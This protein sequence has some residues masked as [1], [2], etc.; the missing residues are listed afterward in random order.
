MSKICLHV[1]CEERRRLSKSTLGR[2]SGIIYPSRGCSWIL[3]FEREWGKERCKGK[4]KH[5]LAGVVEKGSDHV[6]I[7]DMNLEHLQNELNN[8]VTK[9]ASRKS[10][11]FRT[12]L[13]PMGN[14]ANVVIFS[15]DRM[16]AML[17]NG[18]VSDVNLLKEDVGN[19]PVCVKFRGVPLTEF[20]EDG[21]SDIATKLGTPLMLDYY[22]SDMYMQL[23]G[24]SSY[25]RPVIELRA[26]V[27]LKDTIV[28]AMPKLVGDEFYMCTIRVE[29]M[30]E[31]KL[32]LVDDDGNPLSKVVSTVNANSDCEVEEVFVE[33]ESKW[34]DDYDPYDDDMYDSH[35]MSDNL[36]AICDDFD[37]MVLDRKK[38]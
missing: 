15:K 14:G 21:L 7:E 20:S 29:K 19:V 37:I 33:H 28:V 36:Q 11:N 32:L 22:T 34:D 10:V 23:C 5:D 3:E 1:A 25:A 31:G 35:N 12:L 30:I 38:K 26:D 13:A 27:E 24:R 6:P 4:Q 8:L 9:E 2:F 18:N 17:E 16:I